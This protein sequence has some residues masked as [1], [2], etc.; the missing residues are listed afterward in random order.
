MPYLLTVKKR[1]ANG[2]KIKSLRDQ[3]IV[4]GVVYGP[5]RKENV[6]IEMGEQ[7]FSKLYSEAGESSLII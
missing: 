6:S 3:Q 2:K 7:T 1:E 4:P 5:E